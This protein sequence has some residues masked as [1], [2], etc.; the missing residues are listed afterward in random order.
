MFLDQQ[1]GCAELLQKFQNI[2]PGDIGLHF[3]FLQKCADQ[4]FHGLLTLKLFEEEGAD[5]IEADDAGEVSGNLAAGD[6]Q[7]LVQDL[8]DLE[9]TDDMQ[10]RFLLGD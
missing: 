5:L 1:T 3:V 10:G 7:G 4:G 2:L 8:P 9:T 6:G